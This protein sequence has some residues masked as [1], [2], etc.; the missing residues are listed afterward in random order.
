MADETIMAIRARHK[1]NKWKEMESKLEERMHQLEHR[2]TNKV[3]HPNW[4]SDCIDQIKPFRPRQNKLRRPGEASQTMKNITG[5]QR[6]QEVNGDENV[7][8]FVTIPNNL[9]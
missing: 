8:I 2:V 1:G 9:Y 3:L 6:K 5:K 4:T 7:T